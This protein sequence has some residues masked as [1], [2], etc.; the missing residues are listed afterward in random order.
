MKSTLSA[1]AAFTMLFSSAAYAQEARLSPDDK[2]EII[3]AVI[4]H[5]RQN[6]GELL[7]SGTARPATAA[8][9]K[10]DATPTVDQF[11]GAARVPWSGDPAAK[12]SVMVFSDYGCEPCV[13]TETMLDRL[14]TERPSLKIVHNDD[15]VSGPDA[16]NAS[17][18]LIAAYNKGEDWK[19]L[20]AGILKYGVSPDNLRKAFDGAGIAVAEVTPEVKLAL[21]RNRDVAR[22]AGVKALPAVIVIKGDSVVPIAGD[23]TYE[24]VRKAIAM[25]DAGK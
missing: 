14:A 22:R 18:A 3:E 10:P 4:E 8:A 9:A 24:G 23:V 16:V 12:V 7:A 1:L 11:D 25:L 13:A 2:K 21:L 17:L 6:P 19:A 5:F 15:P 20:R